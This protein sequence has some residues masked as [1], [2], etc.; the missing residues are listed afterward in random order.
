MSAILIKDV[1]TARKA[2][3]KTLLT[4]S[5]SLKVDEALKALATAGVLSAPLVDDKGEASGFVDMM[6]VRVSGGRKDID[7][8]GGGGG[9]GGARHL[10]HHAIARHEWGGN[11]IPRNSSPDCCSVFSHALVA[12]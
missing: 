12:F 3:P 2:A 10:T 9:G 5:P 1:L 7:G 11:W 4:L 6:D 8:G